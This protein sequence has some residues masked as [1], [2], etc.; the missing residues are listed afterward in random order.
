MSQTWNQTNQS[1][2]NAAPPLSEKEIAFDL[3]YQE[4]A[5]FANMA[6]DVLEVSHPGLRQVI[7]DSYLQI[8]QDQLALFQIMSGLNWYETKPATQQE[9]QQAKQKYQQMRNTL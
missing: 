8:G 6:S 2:Q 9:V 5:I 7:N 4:K 3:L 1:N